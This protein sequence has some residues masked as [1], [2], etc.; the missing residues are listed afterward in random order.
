MVE[1]LGLDGVHLNDGPRSVRQARKD[2][3]GDAIV[4]AH[5]GTSRHDGIS[6]AESGADY[7]SFGPV[8]AT[9]LGDGAIAGG[10]LFS[11]WS[12]MIEV[13]V[14]AE[15]FLDEETV[16][17]LCSITDF[18]AIGQEIWDAENPQEHLLKLIG[19]VG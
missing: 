19:C 7:V 2:L 17:I 18:F 10:D 4:G 5:C 15:G 1:R 12:E 8:A 14:V 9:P 3:G 13:P 6:A 11:W 16:R